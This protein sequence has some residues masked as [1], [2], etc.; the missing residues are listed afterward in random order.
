MNIEKEQRKAE[1]QAKRCEYRENPDRERE[2]ARR[3]FK[4]IFGYKPVFLS[5]RKINEL[6]ARRKIAEKRK[7][8][9]LAKNSAYGKVVKNDAQG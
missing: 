6:V 1:R 7:V 5:T 4:Q 2:A 9:K 3:M 8:E